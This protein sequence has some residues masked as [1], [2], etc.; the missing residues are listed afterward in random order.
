MK[1]YRHNLLNGFAQMEAINTIPF[2]ASNC[3]VLDRGLGWPNDH[4]PA[5]PEKIIGRVGV[6]GV[7]IR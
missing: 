3:E 7:L 2:A 4:G 1:T 6:N 5:R